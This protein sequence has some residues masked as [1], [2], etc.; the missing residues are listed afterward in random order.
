MSIKSNA[1]LL[2]LRQ[3]IFNAIK[4]NNLS[5]KMDMIKLQAAT[6]NLSD[7]ELNALIEEI[8]PQVTMQEK[9]QKTANSKRNL[10]AWLSVA[11]IVL[12]WVIGLGLF[13]SPKELSAN[14]IDLSAETKI[15]STQAAALSKKIADFSM[16]NKELKALS[17]ELAYSAASAA[18]T[19]NN[20][21]NEAQNIFTT[22]TALWILLTNIVS[23][24]AI[25]LVVA[26]IINKKIKR[27]VAD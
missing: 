16:A 11:V 20:V 1:E 21:A 4:E 22:S 6:I 8:K 18:S 9:V 27:K 25:V 2:L 26:I 13:T 3:T 15:V 24:L 5:S 23:V 17:Q 19:A 10:I 7:E 14:A 12:E